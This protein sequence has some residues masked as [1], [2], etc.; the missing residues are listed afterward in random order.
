VGT[1]VYIGTRVFVGTGVLVGTDVFVGMAVAEAWGAKVS[2]PAMLTSK[3][4]DRTIKA[5]VF[6]SHLLVWKNV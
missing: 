3:T 1:G 4:N 6:I 5:I 2:H